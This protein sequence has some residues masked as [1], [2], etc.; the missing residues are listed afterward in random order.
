MAYVTS[1]KYKDLIYDENS[2]QNVRVIIN[3]KEVDPSYIKSLTFED[4]I[5]ENQSF[6]LGSAITSKFELELANEALESL[7]DFTEVNF[8]FDLIISEEEKETIP[9]GTYIVKNIDNTDDY[10][11]KFTL[12]D[13]MDKFDNEIDYSSIVPCTRFELLKYICQTFGV[14]LENTSFVNG[15]VLVNVYDNSIKAKTYL[16]YISERAGGFA[17]ITRNNKLVIK[18]F[19]EV[20]IC[21]LPE[22]MLG[23][24]TTDNKKIISKVVYENGIQKFEAG[25]D[26]GETIFLTN[27]I[28]SC[29][30]EEV[31][32]IYDVVKGI[33]Y[34]SLDVEIWGDPAID[35]GDIIKV[36]G[37]TS[38][39]QKKWQFGN[40]FYGSYKTTF[41]EENKNSVVNKTTNLQKF[42]RLLSEINELEAK[43]SILASETV[44]LVNSLTG[45]GSVEV[46]SNFETTAFQLKIRNACQRFKNKSLFKSSTKY[47][48]GRYLKITYEDG[49]SN[50]YEL[51]VLALR[52]YRGIYDELNINSSKVS[53]TKRIGVSENN[54]PYLLDEPITTTYDDIPLLLKQGKNIIQLESFPEA[55]FDITY[56]ID[57]MYTD[58]FMT[59]AEVT[60]LLEITAGQIRSEV[61]ET[62][63][64][65][66][67]AY[68]DLNNKMGN[69][70][71]NLN[72]LLKRVE[73]LQT[74]TSYS[75]DILEERINGGVKEVI[76]ENNFSFNKDGLKISEA[77]APTG[78][79]IDSAGSE[80]VDKTGSDEKTLQYNGYVDER[81][82]NKVELLKKYEGQTV[83]YSKNLI[84]EEY[85]SSPNFRIE[86]FEDEE[87]GTCLGFFYTGGE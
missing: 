53:I 66:D 77:G 11:T 47:L 61:S 1:E 72:E 19:N 37:I 60:A 76:T 70:E 12:Y 81:M 30:Q 21:E 39:A 69:A 23:E 25:D 55:I 82:A 56:M 75:I 57:N 2:E 62:R 41:N 10:C 50:R 13:Y 79:T 24:Y 63:T 3:D 42:R 58:T 27:D 40:G 65:L 64:L 83:N 31:N 46:T 73:T 49:T 17:K 34:Q 32:N 29:S 71:D 9:L 80:I 4:E 35:T 85:L 54:E 44:N 15:D 28:F 14:E 26:S 74:S 5:F 36:N 59:N 52:Q 87:K 6:T 18:S 43:I 86:E 16:S 38:F 20:A 51:P 68:Q 48:K 45:E 22:N 67:N 7:G 78:Q 84:F 33:E 8:E